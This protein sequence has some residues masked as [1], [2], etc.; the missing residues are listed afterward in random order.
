MI[1]AWLVLA[2]DDAC[3]DMLG[4]DRDRLAERILER[5]PAEQLVKAIAGS[6]KA[7]LATRNIRDEAGDLSIEIGRNAAQSV[8]FT[9]EGPLE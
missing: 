2:I 8:L 3:P 1:P 5:V 4:G 7:V 9:L 6:A